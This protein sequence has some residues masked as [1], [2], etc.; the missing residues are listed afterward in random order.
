MISEIS[1]VERVRNVLIHSS[2]SNNSGKMYTIL[3]LKFFDQE[4]G[5]CDLQTEML[6]VGID[7]S[8]QLRGYT[9]H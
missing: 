5:F 1:E 2:Q 7:E 3:T 4:N 9:T 8:I 6:R